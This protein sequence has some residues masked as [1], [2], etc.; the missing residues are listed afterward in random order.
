VKTVVEIAKECTPGCLTF[1]KESPS[2]CTEYSLCEI[3]YHVSRALTVYGDERVKEA[4]G[5]DDLDHFA[6]V[7]VATLEEAAR[8]FDDY[9]CLPKCDSTGHE[10]LCPVANPASAI[11]ALKGTP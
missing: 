4:W 11:R 6:R 1:S 8:I 5:K 2:T 10:D 9:K 7:R 3:H